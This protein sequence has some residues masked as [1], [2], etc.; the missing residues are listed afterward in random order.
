M[1]AMEFWTIF[2]ISSTFNLKFTVLPSLLPFLLALV[3]KYETV[4]EKDEENNGKKLYAEILKGN[5]QKRNN[6][7]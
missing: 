2:F 5:G 6:K 4:T 1:E 3:D 7:K